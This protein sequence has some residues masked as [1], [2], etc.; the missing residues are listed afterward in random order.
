ML[1]L[2]ADLPTAVNNGER[3]WRSEEHFDIRHGDAEFGV[4]PD[5]LLWGLQLSDWMNLRRDF[6]LW[7]FN[8]VD[9]AIDYG[10]SGNW[11]KCSLHYAMFRSVP[12]PRLIYLNKS[13]GA[14]EWN[15]MVC[16]CLVQGMAL[17]VGVSLL[18]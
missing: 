11:T 16:I 3:K 7:T 17:L 15:V 2:N 9:T 14:R 12:P 6:E 5:V 4:C 13:I 1:L 10:D 8:I 18:E